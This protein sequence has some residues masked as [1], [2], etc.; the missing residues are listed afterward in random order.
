MFKRL[1][2]NIIAVFSLLSV[3]TVT[4]I[5]SENPFIGSW[6]LVSGKY[7]DGKGQWVDYSD[8]KLSAIKVIS[9]QYFSF[10]TVKNTGTDEKT[11]NEFWAAG[12]GSYTFT[13]N[14]YVE[15]PELNSFGVKSGVSFAFTYNIEGDVWRSERTEEG[16]L[17]EVEV[18]Q[19]LD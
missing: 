5:A 3:T 18:W 1:L 2:I 19:K 14:D 8:L 12:S 16:E 11:V 4:A 15:S 10:T 6:Q 13:A 9:A 17:K 7:L